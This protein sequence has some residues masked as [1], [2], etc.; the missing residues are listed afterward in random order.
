[1]VVEWDVIVRNNITDERSDDLFSI[2]VP[3]CS[4]MFQDR[5]TTSLHVS[6]LVEVVFPA[7]GI[8]LQIP[9]F[10][11]VVGQPHA[12]RNLACNW[13]GSFFAG[14]LSYPS[15]T[16][17]AQIPNEFRFLALDPVPGTGSESERVEMTTTDVA[18]L[19]ALGIIG[20]DGAPA[21]L[22]KE[23]WEYLFDDPA[24]YIRLP[25]GRQVLQNN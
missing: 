24:P 7:R 11:C 23:I 25:L 19:V 14:L 9:D 2:L 10:R 4:R 3:G 22:H 17:P 18:T 13:F 20:F 6:E 8:A 1:V 12:I 5:F 21:P 15:Q 16:L